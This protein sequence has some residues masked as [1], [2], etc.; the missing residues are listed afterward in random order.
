MQCLKKYVQGSLTTILND[1]LSLDRLGEG[2]VINEKERFDLD[3][4][5]QHVIEDVQS[6]RKAGQEI[7]CIHDGIQKITLD[8]KKLGYIF[9]ILISNTCKYS[10]ENS[11]IFIRSFATDEQCLFEFPIRAS[12]FRKMNRSF[13]LKSFSGRTTRVRYREPD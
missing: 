9:I 2:K 13:Y 3:L 7:V 6:H 1:F 8:K 11:R 4:F 5:L 12:A 10:P